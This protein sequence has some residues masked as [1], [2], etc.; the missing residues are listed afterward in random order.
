M[1]MILKESGLGNP[2]KSPTGKLKLTLGH[3]VRGYIKA[4]PPTKHQKALPPSVYRNVL[5]HARTPIRRARTTLIA[6][7]LFFAMRS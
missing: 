7:A 5:A 2:S 6:G 4:D 1:C 3:Q